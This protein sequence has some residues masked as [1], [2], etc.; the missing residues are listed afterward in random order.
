MELELGDLDGRTVPDGFSD[1]DPAS[2]VPGIDDMFDD[3]AFNNNHTGHSDFDPASPVQ[4]IGDMFFG[5]AHNNDLSHSDL[6][7]F[8]D[9]P[10]PGLGINDIP[11]GNGPNHGHDQN[12]LVLDDLAHSGTLDDDA[13]DS[14][15]GTDDADP[16]EDW[17]PCLQPG[18]EGAFGPIWDHSLDWKTYETKAYQYHYY[19]EIDFDRNVV[20][21]AN[22]S[23]DVKLH[24]KRCRPM[25]E[26]FDN[27]TVAKTV[28]VHFPPDSMLS[29]WNEFWSEQRGLWEKG[30]LVHIHYNGKAYGDGELYMW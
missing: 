27:Y 14:V 13:V 6:N 1:F 19:Y 16:K 17:I 20:P 2:P 12:E 11:A 26:F 22:A 24:D 29:D 21:A 15:V 3:P 7:G 30:T 9:L 5:E 25:V 28:D 8:D 4:S 18:E 10:P 23:R